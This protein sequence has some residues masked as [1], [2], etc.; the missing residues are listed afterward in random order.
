MF[1]LVLFQFFF[2]NIIKNY[3]KRIPHAFMEY[4]YLKYYLPDKFKA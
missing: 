1:Y 4:Y 3:F 2:Y